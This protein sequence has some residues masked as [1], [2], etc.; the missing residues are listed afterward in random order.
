MKTKTLFSVT[1]LVSLLISISSIAPDCI[2]IYASNYVSLSISKLDIVLKEREQAKHYLDIINHTDEMVF[3]SAFK[4]LEPITRTQKAQLYSYD[5]GSFWETAKQNYNRTGYNAIESAEPPFDYKWRYQSQRALRSPVVAG[6]NMFI[7][8]EDGKMYRIDSRTGVFRESVSFADLIYSLHL[9]DRHLIALTNNRVKVYDRLTQTHLWK[10]NATNDN[11]KGFVAN[12]GR[13]YIA[14]G[15]S[16]VCIDQDTGRLLWQ[17]S[18]AYES[19]T[20]GS[21][22]VFALSSYNVLTAFDL[23]DGKESFRKKFEGDIIGAPAYRDGL[24]YFITSKTDNESHSIIKCM[25]YTG[26]ILWKHYADKEASASLTCDEQWTYFVSAMGNLIVFNRFSGVIEYKHDFRSPIHISPTITSSHIFIGLNNGQVIAINKNNWKQEWSKD[27]KF[28]LYSELVIAQ[29]LIYTTD[30]SGNMVAYG[31][32]WENVVPPMS[33]ENARGFP[34]NGLVTLYWNVSRSQPDLAGYNIY[35]KTDTERDF[36]FLEKLPVTNQ[37]QDTTV[38]NGQRYHYIV[39]AYDLFGN[40]STNSSQISLTPSESAPPVWVDISPNN[41]VIMPNH[42]QSISLRI[43]AMSLPSGSYKAYVNFILYSPELKEEQFLSFEVNLQIREEA[44]SKPFAPTIDNIQGSD[45]R[46]TLIWKPV[47]GAKKYQ[48]FRSQVSLDQYQL[49]NEV[50]ASI[51]RYQDD[52]VLNERRYFYALKAINEAGEASDFSKEASVIPK[53]LPLRVNLRDHAILHDP[54]TSFSGN[55]DPKATIKVNLLVFNP[56]EQGRFSAIAG[57]P[58]GYSDLTVKAIDTEGNAQKRI[59]PVSFHPSLLQVQLKI[60]DPKVQVNQRDWPYLLDAPPLIRDQ[61]TFV[62]LR[63]LGEIIGAKVS[64]NAQERRVTYLYNE[65]LVE[66]WIGS[67]QIRIDGEYREI[68]VAPFIESG[69]T[70]VPLRFIT[71]P[72]GA[73]IQWDPATRI[74]LLLFQL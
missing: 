37:Y 69:R 27:F 51:T 56:D 8:G 63:F 68:D 42:D 60:D 5:T 9:A 18:G 57:V 11:V 62:P 19:L 55:A 38:T 17:S 35:R 28:P 34:G 74:I 32:S 21:N 66:L 59:I 31:R 3:F 24:L 13:F 43:R 58:V 26:N 7:P 25:D 54:V 15:H 53:P 14:T 65:T 45:T 2:N 49:I 39:R 36:S 46:A 20:L 1:L 10:Y 71:E 22:L 61:R 47:E 41:G 29:G 72:M 6:R 70:L 52:S 33:P 16:V 64:W 40:E 30:Q 4:T 12:D 73:Q 23:K 44:S 67:K 48:I 50:D